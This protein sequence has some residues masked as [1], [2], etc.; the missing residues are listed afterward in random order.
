MSI[1]RQHSKEKDSSQNRASLQ[2]DQSTHK[3]DNTT[4]R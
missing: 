3:Q 4:T 2:L 1:E